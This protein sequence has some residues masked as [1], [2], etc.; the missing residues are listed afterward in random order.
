MAPTSL[1]KF[2]Y[3]FFWDINAKKLNPRE[4]PYFVIQRLLDKGDQEAVRWVRRNFSSELIKETFQTMRDF[5]PQKGRFWS[6]F[7]NLPKKKVLCLQPHYLKMRRML[8][9]Y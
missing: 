6:I 2:L 8:W 7:L 3:P 5:S 1:P 4:K 9:P